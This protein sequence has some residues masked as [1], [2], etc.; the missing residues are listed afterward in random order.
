MG[1]EFAAA[2]IGFVLVGYWI[3]RHYGCKPKGVLIGAGLGILGGGY[4]LIRAAL[5]ASKQMNR[6]EKQDRGDRDE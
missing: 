5:Q 4:N 1:F 6:D 2:I 3:D